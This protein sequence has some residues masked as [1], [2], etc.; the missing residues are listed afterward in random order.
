MKTIWAKWKLLL[1]KQDQNC[2]ST[3]YFILYGK[4]AFTANQLCRQNV[5]RETTCSKDV[6]G[7]NTGNNFE[8]VMNSR[9]SGV[10]FPALH[11]PCTVA[12]IQVLSLV[13][14]THLLVFWDSWW[15]LVSSSFCFLLPLL[16]KASLY[17]VVYSSY[18]SFWL[19]YVG[20]QCHMSTDGQCHVCTQDPN[21]GNPG[22]LK[23]SMWT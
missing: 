13:V 6:Y 10:S 17:I 23:Q 15:Y 21:Q 19:C 12:S 20:C 14:W 4:I 18:G 7:K 9:M 11:F 8:A 3:T 1:T 22:L 16:P 5:C 2:Q